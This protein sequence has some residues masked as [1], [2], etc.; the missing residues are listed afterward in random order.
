[1]AF[2]PPLYRWRLPP[3]RGLEVGPDPPR[4]VHTYIE[5][6]P[7]DLVKYEVDDK[8][9]GVLENDDFWKDVQEKTYA[10]KNRSHTKTR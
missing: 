2:P 3:W 9:I 10:E 8:I 4:M 7:F 1:M 5:L 6:T